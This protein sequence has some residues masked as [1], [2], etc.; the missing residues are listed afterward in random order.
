[1]HQALL[2][3]RHLW[4][5][6]IDAGTKTGVGL[7][8]SQTMMMMLLLSQHLS[9]DVLLSFLVTLVITGV[10]PTKVHQGYGRFSVAFQDPDGFP[11]PEDRKTVKPEDVEKT[12]LVAHYGDTHSRLL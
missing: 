3:H 4:Y 1:M 2:T 5:I 7:L 6:L 12:S 10:A 11:K 9:Q 8:H